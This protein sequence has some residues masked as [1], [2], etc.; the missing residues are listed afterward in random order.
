MFEVFRH[1]F[2]RQDFFGELLLPDLV[3]PAGDPV[4]VTPRG[5]NLPDPPGIP[6]A[7]G[8][9]QDVVWELAKVKPFFPAFSGFRHKI[10]LS[11]QVMEEIDIY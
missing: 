9:H 4:S 1:A 3:A 11:R 8:A 10:I 6:V 7:G 2:N 5:V